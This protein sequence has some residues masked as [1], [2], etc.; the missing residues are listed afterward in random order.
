[1]GEGDENEEYKE[2]VCDSGADYHMTVGITV[3]DKLEDIQTHFYV[4]QIK[5][6]VV[7]SQRGVV[8]LSI[9]KANGEKGELELHKVLFMPEIRVN[10]FCLQ[11]I[12][13]K[14][15]CSYTFEGEPQ[16]GKVIPIMN[17]GREQKATIRETLEAR[18]TLISTRL[19]EN[20]DMEGE[21]LGGKE[22]QLELLH[23]RLGHTS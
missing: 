23:E 4:K 16:L 5:G 17:R 1:M 21:V 19:D 8:R 15:A 11:R 12:R 6:K 20:E 18:P 7:V 3:F 14:G 22:I 13:K 10:I 2:W 9:D